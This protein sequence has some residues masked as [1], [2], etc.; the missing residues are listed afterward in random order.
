MPALAFELGS[1]GQFSLL[2]HW[3]RTWTRTGVERDTTRMGGRDDVKRAARRTLP[4]SEREANVSAT[5]DHR[6][7]LSAQ[8][9]SLEGGRAS[10]HCGG[11][12]K[13]NEKK[14]LARR[15]RAFSGLFEGERIRACVES[16]WHHS[17]PNNGTN[18][19]HHG[20]TG[21]HRPQ[22]LT[23]DTISETLR[24]RGRE[25]VREGRSRTGSTR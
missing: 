1:P 16:Q 4:P 12:G 5:A 11:R 20:R 10:C 23:N 25:G 14:V 9:H 17:G 19:Q 21:R 7:P 3:T 15:V 8:S 24:A 13:G 2:G 18:G 6:G 22:A